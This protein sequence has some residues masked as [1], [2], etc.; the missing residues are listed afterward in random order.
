MLIMAKA[1]L[2]RVAYPLVHPS[3][4][5]MILGMLIMVMAKALARVLTLAR[6]GHLNSLVMALHLR[7][8]LTRAALSVG[9]CVV[10]TLVG[11]ALVDTPLIP[12]CLVKLQVLLPL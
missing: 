3:T 4:V 7:N 1:L 12:L 10:H 2:E 11:V 6:A 9:Q 5:V 8:I